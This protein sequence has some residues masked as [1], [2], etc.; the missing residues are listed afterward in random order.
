MPLW[1]QITTTTPPLAPLTA[2]R[3]E[4]GEREEGGAGAVSERKG[5]AAVN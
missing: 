4:E 2:V 1:L 5:G 3:V